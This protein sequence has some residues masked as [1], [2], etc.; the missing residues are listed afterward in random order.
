MAMRKA[1]RLPVGSAAWVAE[2][3]ASALKVAEEEVEEFSYAARNEMDWLNEH[4]EDIFLGENQMNIAEIFKTPAR[5]RGKTPRTIRKG[6]NT[7]VRVPLASI[8]SATPKGVTPNPFVLAPPA[9]NSSWTPKIR[10]DTPEAD[11]EADDE[12]DD[13][14]KNP[15]TPST[16][17]A[18]PRKSAAAKSPSPVKSVAAPSRQPSPV[19]PNNTTPM[20]P[21]PASPAK[22]VAATPSK[23][24]SPIK[25]LNGSPLPILSKSPTPVKPSDSGYYGSQ[26]LDIMDVD[27][28]G[29]VADANANADVDVDVDMG[30][31]AHEPTMELT[32][33]SAQELPQQQPPQEPTQEQT[34]ESIQPSNELNQEPTQ[35]EPEQ[36]EIES[37]DLGV[38]PAPTEPE[39]HASP[40]PQETAELLR[41]TTPSEEPVEP[42]VQYP[43]LLSPEPDVIRSSSPVHML[44]P[45]PT[46]SIHAPSPQK[47]ASPQKLASPEKRLSPEKRVSPVKVASPQKDPSPEKIP[48]PEKTPELEKEESPVDSAPVLS[49]KKRSPETEPVT[50]QQ[51]K[52]PA[53]FVHAQSEKDHADDQADDKVDDDANS[54]MEASSPISPVKRLSSLNFASLPAREPMTSKKSLGT[55]MSRTSHVDVTRTSFYH[56]QTGGK[57]LGHTTRQDFDDDDDEMDIDDDHTQEPRT[58]KSY[59]QRLQDQINMLGKGQSMGPRPSKSIA[60]LLPTQQHASTSQAPTTQPVPEPTRSSPKKPPVVTP[61]AFPTPGA[62]PLDDDD[63]WIGPPSKGADMSTPMVWNARKDTRLSQPMEG[64]NLFAR[65]ASPTLGE[66]FMENRHESPSKAP[67]IQ[68]PPAASSSTTHVKSASVPTLPSLHEPPVPKTA[69]PKK[70]AS[71]ST[72]NLP[73]MPAHEPPSPFKSPSK[74]FRENTLERVKNKFSSLMKSSKGL[75]PTSAHSNA[76]AKLTGLFTT[77]STARL[78]EHPSLSEASFKTADNVVYPDLSHHAQAEAPVAATPIRPTR[79]TRASTER[80]R[81]EAEEREKEK[82]RE[83]KEAKQYAKTYAKQNE[84]LEKMREKEAEKARLFQQEQERQAEMERRA[85]E[86]REQEQ[87][88]K[89]TKA[90]PQSKQLFETP[91]PFKSAPKSPK[92]ATRTSLRRGAKQGEA[93]KEE[94]DVDMGDVTISTKAP[95]SIPR[96]PSAQASRGT[97]IK[98][99]IRPTKEALTRAKPAPTRIRVNTT[100]SQQ[101]AFHTST[102]SVLSTTSQESL[103]QSHGRQQLVSKASTSSL[104]KK[105]SL[106]SLKGSYSLTVGRPKALELAAKQKEQEERE[107]QRRRDQKAENERKRAEMK[108]EEQR[109]Q[110][111]AA[112][113]AAIEQAKR[114]RAPPP[115]PRSQPNGPPDH[116]AE[117]RQPSR[118]NSRLGPALHDSR[119]VNAVLGKAASKRP[120][121]QVQEAH[122]DSKR[123][124]VSEDFDADIEMAEG[125]TKQQRSIRGAPVRPSAVRPSGVR[126]SAAVR[127]PSVGFKKDLSTTTTTGKSIFASNYTNVPHAPPPPSRTVD[128]FKKTT[129]NQIKTGH[130]LDTAQ[131]QKGNQIPFASNPNGAGPS[132]AAQAGSSRHPLQTPARPGATA[133]RA[134]ALTSATK[135]TR[136]SPRLAAIAAGD[137]IELPEIQTDDE[138][139]V[140]TP[141]PSTSNP[142]LRSSLNGGNWTDSPYLKAQLL[143]QEQLDPMVIF[144]PPAPLNM[145]EVFSKDKSRHHRFRARTSS[146]NW[147]GQDRLTEEEVCRD[148]EARERMRKEGGWSWGLGRTLG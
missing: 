92:K 81:K 104:T 27:E 126:P 122:Q 42:T 56:R 37:Q 7:E 74:A 108:E 94:A 133:A 8:F 95:Q 12:A 50:E 119:P 127:Q 63:D 19:R 5:P 148:R 4:M 121:T 24:R 129:V 97:G 46:R 143:A 101:G 137:S 21:P 13:V 64:M 88:H 120:L 30:E 65:E 34:E 141:R 49:P 22:P 9:N 79:K 132:A 147:E 62:F 33:Q 118:P 20:R 142:N 76:E 52:T 116:L 41:T 138:D 131:F 43:R 114:T 58:A 15:T 103:G 47:A 130:A 96:P 55:R 6:P 3:R 82:K 67:I 29:K 14:P 26:Q 145:E 73:E 23:V 135:P 134:L 60:H 89:L 1:P 87:Q 85:A 90:R 38:Q 2:E 68:E 54:S 36:Q 18:S 84:K 123:I 31:S 111:A 110:A 48:S 66:S 69:S 109:K 112:K 115:P 44:I 136:T 98:R 102:N 144:G 40:A 75:L 61:R 105:P 146:A 17:R 99:P 117:S 100:S 57:S 128:L 11:V 16:R 10:P 45:S 77:P 107:I 80:E 71:V 106:Q 139:G 93:E 25:H 72:S 53:P 28:V 51:P 32:Q 39:Q 124:R 83:E 70:E 86:Q 113:K 91:G 35:E 140:D 125:N 78:E 59:T